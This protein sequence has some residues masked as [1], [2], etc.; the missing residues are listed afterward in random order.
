MTEEYTYENCAQFPALGEIES[1]VA[2][3]IN[4]QMVAPYL[5]YH[6]EEK[7]LK[8]WFEEALSS[9]QKDVLDAIVAQ[10]IS[11]GP[12]WKRETGS[13]YFELVSTG[14]KNNWV[15]YRY[16]IDFQS[17]FSSAPTV[18]L[19]NIEVG[20]VADWGVVGE[21]ESYFDFVVRV[22]NTKWGLTAVSFDWEARA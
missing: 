13:E 11:D 12:D 15:T 3:Q 16:R 18:T 7:W 20:G 9:A 2:S 22:R 1:D 19:S 10:A 8:I 4:S 6:V 21:S 14:N 17:R 5:S